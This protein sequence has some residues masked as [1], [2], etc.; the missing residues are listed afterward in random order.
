LTGSKK[1]ECI[2]YRQTLLTDFLQT[3]FWSALWDYWVCCSKAELPKWAA[4]QSDACLYSCFRQKKS[5]SGQIPAAV[6]VP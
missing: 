6:M 4:S 5:S 2:P 1:K 3:F